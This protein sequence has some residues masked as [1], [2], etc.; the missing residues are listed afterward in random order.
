MTVDRRDFWIDV[1]GTFTDCLAKMPNEQLLR[2]KLLSSGATKGLVGSDSTAARIVDALRRGN[3]E[4]FWNGFCFSLFDRSGQCIG[5]SVVEKCDTSTGSLYLQEPLQSPPPVGAA[6]ELTCELEAPVIGIRYLLKLPLKKPVPAIRLRLGTTR[7][8]NA[9]LTRSGAKTALVTTRGF[10]DMLAIGYQDRPR[11]F[12]LTVHKPPPLAEFSL[13]I[14]ERV[15]ADGAVLKVPVAN[16]VRQ[17]LVR[18]REQGVQSLAICLLHADLFPAH[19]QMVKRIAAEV[20]FEEISC[21]SE[22]APLAKI[23]FRGE[24]TVVDAYLNPVLREYVARLKKSLPGS[25]IR[26]MTSAGGLVNA[27]AFRGHESVLSGPAGGVVGYAQVAQQAGFDRAI[28]FDM[29]GTSTDVSRFDGVYEYEFETHKAGVRLVTPTLAIDTVAAG[30]GSLCQFDG[31]K[32]TVGP[33][34]AGADPGPACYGRGGPLCVTDLNLFLGRIAVD[35]FPFALDRSAV[36]NHLKRLVEEV[37]ASTGEQL[38]PTQLAEGLLQIANANMAQAVRGI[39]VA[40]GANP[41]DYV[42]VSFGGAASQHACA[43][44]RE[45]GIHQ[46]LNH[47]DSGILSAYGIGRADVERH[48]ALGIAK[49]ADELREKDLHSSFENLAAAPYAQIEQEG[50]A[51]EQI[52]IR[53]SLDL[54]YQGADATLNIP[55]IADKD[56]VSAFVEQHRQRYGYAH[57]GRPIEVVAARVEVLGKSESESRESSTCV[58]NHRKANRFTTSCFDGQETRTALFDREDLRPGDV[59]QGPAI[60]AENHST[61]I[62]EPGLQAEMLSGE[63][64]VLSDNDAGGQTPIA[65]DAVMLEV[66]NHLLAGVAE[67]MGHVL[68]RTA[69][70]VNVKERLDYSCAVFTAA[71]ELVANAPHVPVHL[72]AMGITVRAVLTDNPKLGPGDV[73]VTNDPYRGGSHLPDVTVVT[74]VH[75]PDTKELLFFTACR[76]HHAEI[77]GTRPGSMPP[78]SQNLSEEGVLI[79]NFALIRDGVSREDKLRQLLEAGPYPS[80]RVEENLADLR[81]QVAANQHGAGQLLELVERYTLPVVESNIRGIQAAAEAKVRGALAKL[82]AGM[83]QQNTHGSFTDYLE[84]SDDSLVPI[85]VKVTFIQENDRPAAKIDFTGTGP[86][87]VGN[88]NANR[89]I[90]TA[91]VLYVLRLLVDEEIPLNEGALRAVEIVIPEGI[92]NPTAGNTLETMPAV[93]AGNVE[94][95]QRVVDVLLGAFRLAGASQGTMNNVLFGNKAFGYYETICG[96]S[97]ATAEGPGADAVQVHM[98]NTRA[99]DPEVLERR[100]P[101]RLWEFSIR[102]GSGGLGEQCGGNG[103]VR[104]MEFLAPLEL[105]LITQ[106]RGKHPPYGMDGGEAGSLGT[107]QLIKPDGS[108]ETLSAICQLSVQCGDTLVIKTPGGGGFGKPT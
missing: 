3:P 16:M 22:V 37:E 43:V 91:A 108:V 88:L 100:H 44:A 67:Q 85:H 11:L 102:R 9:L 17:Q 103:A 47:P 74:P 13:E 31:S 51:G 104:R 84:A 24:T 105:S 32:L 79:S 45:L 94:T 38:T 78:N 46:V 61:I 98:T 52:Q 39:S 96:G 34:S 15:A 28:G 101:V 40:K 89:A 90:V 92:L 93:S 76:A 10:G 36:E 23:V 107:N 35:R 50:F 55:F 21:S 63:E 75:H 27:D 20:G 30:G 106:R 59:I 72:G 60:V 33:A 77:G 95:S 6:Y 42:L 25:Q 65:A 14:E 4:N 26:L 57:E 83:N 1:G 7:G 41:A 48:A 70:S 71:G 99:T 29:G 2:H 8:T 97:G 56:Y 73:Y 53:R 80:R 62:I 19:E 12:E 49:L 68:R 5:K 87:V 18:L 58:T 69:L 64:L 81:A 86:V 54:R 82:S 66:F